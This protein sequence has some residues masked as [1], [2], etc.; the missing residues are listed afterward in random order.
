MSLDRVKFKI[1]IYDENSK[2]SDE[3]II[4]FKIDN[5]KCFVTLK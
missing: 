3:K 5:Q 2:L 1:E 4:E